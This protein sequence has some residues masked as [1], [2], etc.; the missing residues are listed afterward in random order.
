[1]TDVFPPEVV[2]Q[3]AHHMNEDHAAGSLLICRTLGGR[4]AAT[5]ARVSGLDAD[6]MTFVA[7]VDG[8]PV[9]VTV[10]FST[11]ITER[12]QVRAEVIRMHAE[13]RAALDT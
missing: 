2:A 12:G 1:M 10:P 13:A 4:P 8:R 6:G 7:T 3:I 11:R 9:A 5:E